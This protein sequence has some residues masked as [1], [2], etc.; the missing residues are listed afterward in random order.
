MT[1]TYSVDY[2]FNEKTSEKGGLILSKKI[3]LK[4]G[5]YAIVDD[6]DYDRLNKY[7]WS[8]ANGY[9]STS[10]NKGTSS[11]KMHRM[12]LNCPENLDVGHMNNDNLDNRKSNLK[13]ITIRQAQ[14]NSKKKHSSNYPGVRWAKHI[15]KWQSRIS[16]NG[17]EVS[18][19]CYN[20]ELEAFKAYEKACN[21]IG[22]EIVCKVPE[23]DYTKFTP[24]EKIYTFYDRFSQTSLFPGVSWDKKN[25]KWRA[26]IYHKKKSYN[27]G[28]FHNEEDAII[29]VYNKSIE[30]GKKLK[31]P[32]EW[33]YIFD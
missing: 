3:L 21:E 2:M 11:V 4:K 12:I 33:E 18:L 7:T 13:I 30:L 5:V 15:K 24:Y 31:I 1:L 28:S 14:Q 19:G 22:E 25:K 23:V 6:E 10:V 9:A 20:E 8:F 17:E 32:V 27:L 16:I 26:K 29:Q